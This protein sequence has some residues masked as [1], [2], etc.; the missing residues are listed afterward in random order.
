MSS[1]GGGLLKGGG[2]KEGEALLHYGCL[3]F[4]VGLLLQ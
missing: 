1:I 4:L 3:F 2:G